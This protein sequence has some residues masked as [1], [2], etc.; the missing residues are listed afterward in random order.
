L[1]SRK[2]YFLSESFNIDIGAD[3]MLKYA[4]R[5]SLF[6]FAGCTLTFDFLRSVT[7]EARPS[8]PALKDF[9]RVRDFSMFG[10]RP[11]VSIGFRL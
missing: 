10:I 6:L 4:I 8:N 2:E 3:V 9:G 11:Y 7:L 5:D 1:T